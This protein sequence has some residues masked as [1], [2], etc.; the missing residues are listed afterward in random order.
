MFFGELK[1]FRECLE[2][3]VRPI[4][5]QIA[6]LVAFMAKLPRLFAEC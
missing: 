1:C 2:A 4:G 6:L 5:A 3:K